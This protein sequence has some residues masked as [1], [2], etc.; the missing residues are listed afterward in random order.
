MTE[1]SMPYWSGILAD[2]KDLFWRGWSG[3]AA[4][5][6]IKASPRPAFQKSFS[7]LSILSKKEI[8]VKFQKDIVIRCNVVNR[9]KI[10]GRFGDMQDIIQE[11]ITTKS[12]NNRMTNVFNMHTCAIGYVDLIRAII[13]VFHGKFL[14]LST[15]MIGCPW[16]SIPIGINSIECAV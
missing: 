16:V 8:R 7:W 13:L 6:R 2:T 5:E 10:L 4:K 11:K 1:A 9:G 14:K 12:T 15:D 3:G